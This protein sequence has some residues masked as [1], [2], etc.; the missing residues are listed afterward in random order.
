[1]VVAIGVVS[2]H[3]YVARPILLAKSE[4]IPTIEI[5]PT[6]TDVSEVVDFRFRG[7]PMRVLELIWQT[8]RRRP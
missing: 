6:H 1:M 4:G 2:M 3:P 7:T 5:G 8:F